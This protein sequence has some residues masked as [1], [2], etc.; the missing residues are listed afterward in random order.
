VFNAFYRDTQPRQYVDR[1]PHLTA[2]GGLTLA[3]WNGW[4]ASVR[5]RAINRYRLD[6]EDAGVLAAGQTVFDLSVSRRLRRGVEFNLAVDNLLGRSYYETQN[7]FESRLPGQ[8]PISRIHAT[9]G[10]PRTVIAGLT[11]RLRGK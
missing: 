3:G 10:Y 11:F 2:N 6:P 1:A 5:M 4:Y 9:P 8:E 7:Y